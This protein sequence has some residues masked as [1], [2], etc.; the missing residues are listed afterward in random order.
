MA[1]AWS[2]P[3][4]PQEMLRCYW[5][6]VVRSTNSRSGSS[7][8]SATSHSCATTLSSSELE[9]V[10]DVVVLYVAALVWAPVLVIG[11]LTCPN[12]IVVWLYFELLISF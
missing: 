2:C 9:R 8:M 1:V 4:A 3:S 10:G 6:S 5:K 7:W 12:P 11:I